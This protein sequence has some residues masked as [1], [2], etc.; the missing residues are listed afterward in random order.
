[1]IFL[2]DDRLAGRIGLSE[3]II[4]M[5]FAQR[6][7]S[8]QDSGYPTKNSLWR[9]LPFSSEMTVNRAMKRLK[10]AGY[11]N[12]VPNEVTK[13]GFKVIVTA[14]GYHAINEPYSAYIDD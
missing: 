5:Y 8:L 4:L 2:F 7:K 13:T 10:K 1:M 3:A 11:I 6:P 14:I 12:I 9:D